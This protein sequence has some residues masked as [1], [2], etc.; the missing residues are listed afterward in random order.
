MNVSFTDSSSFTGGAQG[1]GEPTFGPESWN[2]DTVRLKKLQRILKTV[3]NRKS[4]QALLMSKSRAELR[5]MKLESLVVDKQD[6]YLRRRLKSSPMTAANRFAIIGDEMQLRQELILGHP[7]DKRDPFAGRTVLCDAAASGHGHIVLML[8]SEYKA[9]VNVTTMLGES[10][11]LHIAVANGTRQMASMLITFGAN[12]NAK[13]RRGCTPLHNVTKLS[14]VKLLYKFDRLD[15]VVR[16]REGLLPSE[17]Y[18][19]HTPE[20]EQD[21]NIEIA[22]RTREE[23]V[24]AERKKQELMIKHS[25]EGDDLL[26]GVTSQDSTLNPDGSKKKGRKYDRFDDEYHGQEAEERSGAGRVRKGR[27]GKNVYRKPVK[28]PAYGLAPPGKDLYA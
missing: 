8:C 18:V 9:K 13:D 2:L 5:L 24:I 16:S 25:L 19:K 14:L 23:T 11:A 1:P 28:S 7:V 3:Q 26:L 4:N 27:G 22:L 20:F 15:P 17:H 21:P 12:I 10:T 6:E